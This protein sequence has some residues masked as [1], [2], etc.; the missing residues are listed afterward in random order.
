MLKVE[1][2]F[3]QF[4]IAEFCVENLMFYT[5]VA[6]FM[7]LENKD[8]MQDTAFNILET[9]V[10]NGSNFEVRI[11]SDAIREE[12]RKRVENEPSIKVFDAAIEKV[13]NVMEHEIFPRF[14][15]SNLFL[16]YK[17]LIDEEERIEYLKSKKY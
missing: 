3:K 2:Y 4:L 14:L 7:K 16:Q 8:D 9:Y 17:K 6:Y 12:C 5:E 11:I 10:D 15:K 1:N 13:L